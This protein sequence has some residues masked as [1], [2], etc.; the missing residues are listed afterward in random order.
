ML[1][2]DVS[3]AVKMRITQA[4]LAFILVLFGIVMYNDLMRKFFPP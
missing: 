4:G 2:R 3:M 1:R